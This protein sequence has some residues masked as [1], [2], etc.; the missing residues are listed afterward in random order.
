MRMDRV[1]DRIPGHLLPAFGDLKP[2][3]FLCLVDALF[4]VL[5]GLFGEASESVGFLTHALFFVVGSTKEPRHGCRRGR[6]SLSR[7][8]RYAI[9]AGAT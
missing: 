9:P 8:C 4:H 3:V 2:P 1:G 5:A 7:L 6:G